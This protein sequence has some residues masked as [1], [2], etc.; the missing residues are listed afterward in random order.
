MHLKWDQL[1][2]NRN[3]VLLFDSINDYFE[4]PNDLATLS[5]AASRFAILQ[6]K[7]AVIRRDDE[8]EILTWMHRL[9]NE[10]GSK[11]IGFPVVVD[12][13][14]QMPPCTTCFPW[15]DLCGDT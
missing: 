7:R 11:P 2:G 9:S 14:G 15:T 13:D 4:R 8:F 5:S 10:L 3:L 6:C 12:T 1:Q